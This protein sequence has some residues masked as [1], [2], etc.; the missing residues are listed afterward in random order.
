M[1]IRKLS[2]LFVVG[3]LIHTFVYDKGFADGPVASG[4]ATNSASSPA[5]SSPAA[6]GP[7]GIEDLTVERIYGKRSLLSDLPSGIHWVGNS[8]GVSYLEKLGDDD[9]SQKAFIIRSVPKGERRVVCVPDTVAI[10]EDLRKSDDAKFKIGSYSWDKKG[11][12]IV[13]TFGGD[14]FTME[15]KSGQIARRTQTEGKERNPVFSPDRKKVA[16]TRDN[17]LYVMSLDTDD[18]IRLTETGCDSVLNGILDWVYMEEL[19]TRGNK[20]SFYWSPDSERLAFLQ[21]RESPVPQFPIVDWMEINPEL[22][23]QRYPKP[24][25]ANPIVRVGIVSAGG[26]DVVWAD[27]DTRDDSYIARLNWLGG[28]RG[29]AIEK[30]NRA[31]DELTLLFVDARNGGISVVFEETDKTWV[32]LNYL[33]HYYEKHRQFLWGS[34]RSGHQ[35]L[36][37][38]NMDG[39]LIRPIT[40]GNWEV[41]SLD[42]VNESKRRLY[43]TANKSNVMERQLYEVSEKGGEVR[44]ITSEEGHHSVTMSPDNKYFIDKFTSE[45]RPTVVSVHDIKGNKLFEIADRMTPELAAMERP[46]PEFIKFKSGAGIDYYCAITKPANFNRLQKYPVIVYV[47]GGPHAQLVRRGWSGSSLWHSMMAAKGYIIFTLDN[48]GSYGRGKQWE[49]P[50][51]ENLGRVELEDQLAGVEYLRSLPYVDADRIGIWGWSY[52]GFMTLTALFKAPDVFKAGTAVA[53]VTDWRLYDS[54]YTE[55]YMKSPADNE[56]GYETASPINFVDDFQG[57]LLVMHG[58]ADD[59]VHAQNSFQLLE[60]LID[61]GKSVDFMVYPQKTH[62]I[63][64]EEARVFLFTKMTEFFDRHLLDIAD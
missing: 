52:G 54:I 36:Y 4:S 47:Y 14:L 41:T 43:F 64:G 17:D 19:Y 6:S 13:F 57:K 16:Y 59:N 18:E 58:D 7:A 44:Q 55:R 11:E 42:G 20:R 9:E 8:K 26:G 24:G 39:S 46:V 12:R 25:E 3:A 23:M 60:K 28:S 49:D 32:N 2:I 30:L 62:G 1:M 29:V 37:L 63:R 56:E 61:A 34:E 22:E 15:G 21:M 40:S 33:K 31:Q 50:I 10:P 45:K 27:T 38:Y 53:P 48:R 5:T 35:H 51:L